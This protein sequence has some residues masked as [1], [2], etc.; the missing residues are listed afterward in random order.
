MS[1]T[2]LTMTERFRGENEGQEPVSAGHRQRNC[3]DCRHN[4]L[5][6]IH[7]LDYLLHGGQRGRQ[8]TRLSGR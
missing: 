1:E 3:T 7:R 2:A 4:D 6:A 5:H 8:R